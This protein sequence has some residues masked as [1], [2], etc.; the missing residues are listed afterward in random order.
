MPRQPEKYRAVWFNPE[1]QEIFNELAEKKIIVQDFA[2]FVKEAYHARIEQ[3]RD[4]AGLL[5]EASS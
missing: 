3:L 2:R 1:A 4:K 5:K